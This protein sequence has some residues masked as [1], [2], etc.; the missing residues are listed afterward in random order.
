MRPLN[1]EVFFKKL[2]KP[3]DD[4]FLLFRAVAAA[5]AG[6]GREDLVNIRA[7]RFE[8]AVAE[9]IGDEAL[10]FCGL[11]LFFRDDL[12][13]LLL[14]LLLHITLP[15]AVNIRCSVDGVDKAVDQVLFAAQLDAGVN[16]PVDGS[17]DAFTFDYSRE[18]QMIENDAMFS[19]SEFM[20]DLGRFYN[21][22]QFYFAFKDV[23]SGDGEKAFNLAREGKFFEGL[24]FF[25]KYKHEENFREYITEYDENLT[26][27]ELF[28]EMLAEAEKEGRKP[29]EDVTWFAVE[30]ADYDEEILNTLID[31]IPTFNMRLKR[32]PKN[33]QVKFAADVNSVFDIAWYTLAMMIT[34]F[35]P[36]EEGGR[37]R[38]LSD[39]TL[40]TCPHCG[41]A[42]IRRNNRQQYCM[43]EECQKAHNVL[44][45]RRYRESQKIKKTQENNK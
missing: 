21:A 45:Q 28:A 25:E 36:L 5:K 1:P 4:R 22:E 6:D 43:K 34:D 11:Q 37:E 18:G 40:V 32:N 29:R 19:V 16:R 39:G 38:N 2:R 33:N 3:L 42:F 44:R 27:Q 15:I 24:P 35:G 12:F 20:R 13:Q 31:I 30:P 8:R 14:L 9:R 41:E 26:P 7:G 10:R 17:Q 23:C